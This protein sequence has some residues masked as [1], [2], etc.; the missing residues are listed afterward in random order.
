MFAQWMND[1]W[2]HSESDAVLQHIQALGAM[3]LATTEIWLR[4]DS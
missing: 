1:G 2:G 3:C 4:Y